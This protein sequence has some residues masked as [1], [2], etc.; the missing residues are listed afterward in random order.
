MKILHR[1]QNSKVADIWG[2]AKCQFDLEAYFFDLW[3]DS[4]KTVIY[5]FEAIGFGTV[6]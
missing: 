1:T 2:I 4:G 5:G 6:E 3:E